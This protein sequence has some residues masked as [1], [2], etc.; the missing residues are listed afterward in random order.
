MI[1]S[2]NINRL[3]KIKT[4]LVVDLQKAYI[5]TVQKLNKKVKKYK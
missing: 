4:K 5:F 3:S 1:N 2:D